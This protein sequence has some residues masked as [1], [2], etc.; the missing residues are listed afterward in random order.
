MMRRTGFTRR[1]GMDGFFSTVLNIAGAYVGDPQAGDQLA[2]KA[3]PAFAKIT[4][5]PAQI[6]DQVT[7][8]VKAGYTSSASPDLAK[9]TTQ[10]QQ[11]AA[12]VAPLVAANLAKD[13]VMFPAG[14]Y[15]AQLQN[16]STLNAFGGAN[17]KWVYFGVLALA[18]ALVWK[19][20]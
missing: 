19:E 10:S 4:Q 5:T 7:P 9:I 15:G 2:S 6:A 16:P 3:S 11:I 20:L 8:G 18:G 1:P 12:G 17:A 13:G 14:T